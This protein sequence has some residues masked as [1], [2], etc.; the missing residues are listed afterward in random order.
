MVRDAI[1]DTAEQQR[2]QS[3][4]APG[5]ED[6]Q[7]DAQAPGEGDN[8]FRWSACLLMKGAGNPGSA[9]FCTNVCGDLLQQMRRAGIRS[10]AVRTKIRRQAVGKRSAVKH[11]EYTQR[12][13]E[14]LRDLDGSDRGMKGSLRTI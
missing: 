6:N 13:G 9:G 2:S 11:I 7:V 4:P 10:L 14:F 5:A 8:D 1:G 3:A 12:S